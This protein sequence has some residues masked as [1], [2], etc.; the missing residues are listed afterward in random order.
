MTEAKKAKQNHRIATWKV[1]DLKVRVWLGSTL[2]DEPAS[3]VTDIFGVYKAYQTLI[4]QYKEKG[5]T[6]LGFVRLFQQALFQLKVLTP[7]HDLGP[8]QQVPRFLQ[9]IDTPAF[10]DYLKEID[11]NS[12]SPELMDIAAAAFLHF[13]ESGWKS[14]H[15]CLQDELFCSDIG[16]EEAHYH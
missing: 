6:A 8:K 2:D 12:E 11:S 15:C 9:A 10:T 5:M 13:V 3:H 14:L 4:Y 1:E 7:R 16:C